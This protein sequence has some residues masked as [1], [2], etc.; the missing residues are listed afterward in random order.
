MN[1]TTGWFVYI[2]KAR[3]DILEELVLKAQKGDKKAF[4]DLIKA[5]E[6][7]M[8]KVAKAMIFNDE[9]IKDVFQDTIVKAYESIDKLKEPGYFTTW[10]IRIL[11]NNCNDLIKKRKKVISLECVKEESYK[12]KFK[13]I[14]LYKAINQLEEDLKMVII[15]FYFMDMAIKDIAKAQSIAEGTVKSRLNRARKRL[16]EKLERVEGA[17]I[18]G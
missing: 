10:L 1:K 5:N 14:D 18:N 11:I 17:A 6:K 7:S 12:E 9:D 13:D 2:G 16:E 15:M 4:M 8:Y 3:G